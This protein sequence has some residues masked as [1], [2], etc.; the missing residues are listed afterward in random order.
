MANLKELKERRQF[1]V[2]KI[3]AYVL[4]VRNQ[5]SKFAEIEKARR[6]LDKDEKF[7]R[8]VLREIEEG[9]LDRARDELASLD[10]TISKLEMA[11]P[12]RQPRRQAGSDRAI[13]GGSARGVGQ[14]RP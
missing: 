12:G 4:V 2:Q 5:E 3:Q 7:L 10:L 8:T 13:D 1:A 6:A 9:A 11:G 14:Y